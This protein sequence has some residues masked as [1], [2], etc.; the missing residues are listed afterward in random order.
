MSAAGISE[1]AREVLLQLGRQLAEY[2]GLT[3][4]PAPIDVDKPAIVVDPAG[5]GVAGHVHDEMAVWLAER[6]L[7]VD[8]AQIPHNGEILFSITVLT[9]I[10]DEAVPL[11]ALAELRHGDA[12]LS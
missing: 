1:P 2:P 7:E 11:D 10:D 3:E 8:V 5:T 6:L 9:K 4:L 12:V